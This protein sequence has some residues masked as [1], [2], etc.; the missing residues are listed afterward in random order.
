MKL[1]K[2][3]Q[4][5][6]LGSAAT[7]ALAAAAWWIHP[8][9]SVAICCFGVS[10]VVALSYW[11]LRAALATQARFITKVIDSVDSIRATVQTYNDSLSKQ[12]THVSTTAQKASSE[13]SENLVLLA[14]EV[15][16]LG[17]RVDATRQLINNYVIEQDLGGTPKQ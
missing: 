5:L 17:K 3:T 4:L 16:I 12:L 9:L 1:S 15:A 2:A 11:R 13:P 6:I 14:K 7:S 8:A 10:L